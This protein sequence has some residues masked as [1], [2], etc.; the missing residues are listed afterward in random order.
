[1][2]VGPLSYVGLMVPHAGPV[3]R[4]TRAGGAAMLGMLV[5]E[6]SDWLGPNL[7]FLYQIPAGLM[8]SLICGPYLMLLMF[9]R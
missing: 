5:T 3:A 2:I 7:M 6:I 1:L 4:L 8:A 9:R